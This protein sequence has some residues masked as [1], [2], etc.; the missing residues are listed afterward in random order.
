[1][2]G[3][4]TVQPTNRT[5]ERTGHSN[6]VLISNELWQQV[7]MRKCNIV[8]VTHSVE[9]VTNRDFKEHA[10]Y[11]YAHSYLSAVVYFS[12]LTGLSQFPHK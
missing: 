4:A 3:N 7:P 8:L 10:K 6:E 2:N 1:M 12:S 9:P 11:E 5:V